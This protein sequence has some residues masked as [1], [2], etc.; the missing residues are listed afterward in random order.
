MRL[1]VA[2]GSILREKHRRGLERN[3][4][5]QVLVEGRLPRQDRH[6]AASVPGR[7]DRSVGD[8]VLRSE[9]ILKSY[10]QPKILVFW[11]FFA[12]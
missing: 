3:T 5:A 2:S 1:R 10:N 7:L 4:E 11:G 9:L 12:S 8:F 6:G